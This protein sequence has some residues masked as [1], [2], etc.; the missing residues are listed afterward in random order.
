MN[1]S[2]LKKF[3]ED[4]N[5]AALIVSEE[6][7][8][9]FTSFPSSAG[10]L[11]VTAD[12]AVFLTDSRYIEAA[13]KQCVDCD[14][15]LLFKNVKDSVAPVVE[16]LGIKKLAVESG[17]MTLRDLAM[18]SSAINVEFETDNALETAIE[19]IRMIKSRQEIDLVI[20]AQRIAEKAFEHILKF[21]KVGMTEREISLEL[22]YFMLR[23]GADAL[24]F[25]TIAVSG[26]KSSMP[27]GVPGLRKI[28]NGDFITMDYGAVVEGY[29]S[30]M[31]RTIAVGSVT[32]EQK[33]VYQT[34]LDAQTAAFAAMKPGVLCSDVDKAGRDVIKQAGYGDCFGHGLGH[35]VGVEIHEEPRLSPFGTKEL[36]A[37]FLVT[38]EPGI[39]LP[40]K[41][42]VRIEDMAYITDGG[43][44]NL[45]VCPK[46]LITI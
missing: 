7:R 37:G 34:V 40:G 2:K 4:K 38:N 46:E 32:E 3:L 20:K 36:K 16:S 42:G 33:K 15:I 29:H 14:E 39:Y 27:H 9:Y 45:T 23:N 30:D 5:Y 25:E 28:Q 19:D 43:Y 35:G 17:R 26:E 24:S 12:K 41:F 11:I 6:N 10:F 8:R 13:E 22:D 21:I 18:Y 1:I 31:T 44:E